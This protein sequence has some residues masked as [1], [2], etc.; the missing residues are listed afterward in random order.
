MSLFSTVSI[1]VIEAF[2]DVLVIVVGRQSGNHSDYN[3]H[4]RTADDVVVLLVGD[5]QS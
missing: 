4:E 3:L 2:P 1:L 5:L